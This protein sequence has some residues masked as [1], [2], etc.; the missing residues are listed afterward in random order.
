MADPIVIFKGTTGLN[1]V[2]DPVRLPEGDVA[3]IVNMRID[4]S[5]HPSRRPSFELIQSGNFHSLFAYNN[6]CY[7]MQ[8]R[9][10]DDAIMKLNSDNSLVGIASGFDK[11][12]KRS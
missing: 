8:T 2:N 5:G 6:D 3:E 11:A 10:S 12:R 7:V 9:T 1:T 4:Q